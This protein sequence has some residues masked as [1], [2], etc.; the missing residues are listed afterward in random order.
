VSRESLK[1]AKEDRMNLFPENEGK[2][3]GRCANCKGNGAKGKK[4]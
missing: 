4:F 3:G 1:K 2:S